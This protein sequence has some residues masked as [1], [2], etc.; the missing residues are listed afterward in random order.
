MLLCIENY[1]RIVALSSIL[2]I[3]ESQGAQFDSESGFSEQGLLDI[4]VNLR[5][6]GISV[7]D[8][9]PKVYSCVV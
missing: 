1:Y 6:I 9:T 4:S 8:A 7:V 5:G 2:R 3:Y